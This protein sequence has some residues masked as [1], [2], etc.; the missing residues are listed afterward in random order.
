MPRVMLLI[1]HRNQPPGAA[2]KIESF[3]LSG[4]LLITP[5]RHGDS[6]GVFAEV[7]RDDLFR[8]T[9]GETAFLQDNHSISPMKGT[10]RGMHYQIMPHQQGKLV[11]VTQGAIF[12]VAVDARNGSPTYGMHV[13][14]MLSAENWCQLWVPPGFLHGFCTLEPDTHVQY[15]VDAYYNAASDRSI[16]FDD[17]ALNIAWPVVRTDAILSEKDA[18]APEFATLSG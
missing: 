15:K 13:S 17:P 4:P 18:N 1:F 8:K 2:L 16:R 3:A 6:R 9:A 11:R 10:I 5:I 7:F 14:A 12:D